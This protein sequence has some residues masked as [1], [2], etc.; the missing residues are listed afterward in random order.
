MPLA[1]V[2]VVVEDHSA[3]LPH[4]YQ[5]LTLQELHSELHFPFLGQNGE[6]EGAVDAVDRQAEDQGEIGGAVGSRDDGVQRRLDAGPRGENDS[7]LEGD[8][9]VR[10]GLGARR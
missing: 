1:I 10:D 3:P 8:D 4:A 7:G 6:K 5:D 2:D 9:A